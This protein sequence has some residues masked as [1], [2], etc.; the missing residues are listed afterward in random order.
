[1]DVAT[2]E[3]RCQRWVSI[4]LFDMDCFVNCYMKV[5]IA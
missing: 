2:A 4:I 5:L 3:F 1:M